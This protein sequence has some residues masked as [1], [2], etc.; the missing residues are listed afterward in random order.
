MKKFKQLGAVLFIAAFLSL[1]FTFSANVDENFVN[2]VTVDKTTVKIPVSLVNSIKIRFAN[3][4]LPDWSQLSPEKDGYE[5]TRTLELYDYIKSKGI[6]DPKPII[7]AVMDSGFEMDHP[8]L[9]ANVWN[10][11]AEINGAAGV[12][13]DNNGYVDDFHGWNFLGNAVAL[14][15]EVTR[16]YARLKKEGVSETDSYFQKVKKEY[17]SKKDEDVGT[18]EYIKTLAKTTKDAVDVLKANNVT[19]DPK[20]LQ[21][22]SSTLT[23]K[24]KDAAESILGS[25]MLMGVTPDDIFEYEKEFE[26]KTSLS[27]D[28]NFDPSTLIGDNSKVLDEKNYGNNDPSVK[29][30]SHGTH[31]AGT[32]GA[33]KKGIGQAPFVK[34]MFIRVVPADGDE[35]D[36]DIANGIKYAVDNGASIINLSA[37]KYFANNEQYVI[38]AIKYAESKGVLFVAAAGNEGT[39]IETK[40]NYPRKFYTENGQ[41]KYF[42]NLLCV[43]A[44]TWMKQWNTE[45]DPSNLTRKFDLAA[46]FS[47]FSDK[48][49][50]LYSPGVEVNS[51]VP[52]G[53]YQR[54]GG[55]SMAAPNAA[56]VAAI[57]K[58]YFP[59]LN[60]AQLKEILMKSSRKYVG[61]TVKTKELGKVDF[62][63]LSK[64]SGVVDAYNAFMMAKDM[65]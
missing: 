35:R 11:E 40:L 3:A 37:G 28:L 43:G 21:E 65:K 50:D 17:D 39:N 53:K 13:D 26:S 31:V 42:S 5:G 61:L 6:A 15:L 51:T 49:V 30:S 55:T 12:D 29:V 23:G 47:N 46:S 22:I 16:E 48:V 19:T 56:G 38:D 33:T 57:I 45:K 63:K 36:K 41:M 2:L 59:N 27:Y 20:K 9:K 54:M 34:L 60:A 58:G 1:G 18:Y 10:N 44:S 25:Y 7:V 14:N 4:D 64:T 8:D 24:S 32:I 52:G 62:S